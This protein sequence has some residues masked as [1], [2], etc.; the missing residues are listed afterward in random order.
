MAGFFCGGSGYLCTI[1]SGTNPP[2]V[3]VEGSGSD[4]YY[5]EDI[6]A[7]TEEVVQEEVLEETPRSLSPK[8]KIQK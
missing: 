6:N 5:Y 8:M 7:R 3:E 4:Y 2:P 1:A